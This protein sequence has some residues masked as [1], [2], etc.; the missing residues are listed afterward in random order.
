MSNSKLPERPSLEYLKKLAKDRL[1]KLRKANPHAKLTNAQ[2]AIAREYGFSS[3]R[4]LKMKIDQGETNNVARFFEA[5]EKGDVETLRRLLEKEPGLVRA[6]KSNAQYR[7]WSGLHAAAQHGQFEAVRLLLRQGADPNA[8]E[9]GDNTY[10]LHWAAARKDIE[11]VRALLDAGSDVHGI[12]DVHELD[13]IGWAAV[14]R[15]PDDNP[16]PVVSLLLERGARHHIFSAFS[17]GDLDQIRKLVQENPRALDRRL[18][19][20]EGGHTPL[21]FAINRKRYD[22]LDLLIEL[23]AN[24]EAED[25]NGQ[26]ALAFA[27]M[28]GDREAIRRLH[29]AGAKGTRD[30]VIAGAK[31]KL[32]AASFPAAVAKIGGSIHGAAPMIR[33]P[34]IAQTL[35]WYTSIGFTEGGR[36]EYNGVVDW[37]LVRFGKAQLMFMRGKANPENVRLWFYTGKVDRLYELFKG[38]LL[39]TAQA[40]LSGAADDDAGFEFIENINNPIYGGREFGIRDL[41]GYALYFRQG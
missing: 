16:L 31:R 15:E 20:F 12:G 9:T 37:G 10:P 19:R 5:C 26:S 22:I 36:N 38:R 6:E 34:D 41:N 29:A 2:L 39:Q 17:L 30:W 27:L 1:Q 40:S 7:G 3:W 28:R 11:M 25:Q 4:A 23:G 18:S 14:Y 21:H 8:R 24:L 32:D 33:V 35:D 13:V